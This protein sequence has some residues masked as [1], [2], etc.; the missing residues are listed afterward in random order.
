MFKYAGQISPTKKLNL[1][2]NKIVIALCASIL[3]ASYFPNA[4]AANSV[5]L[6]L[7]HLQK[8]NALSSTQG[9]QQTVNVTSSSNAVLSELKK[10]YALSDNEEFQLLKS[11]HSSS[12]Q[13][14]QRYVQTINGVPVYG[15]QV[16]I[17]V[18]DQ[19][20]Y[21]LGG[22]VLVGANQDVQSGALLRT[23]TD[24][25]AKNLAK[26]YFD[27]N[28][29]KGKL[30]T[31]ERENSLATIALKEQQAFEVKHVTF[32][33]TPYGHVANPIRFNAFVNKQGKVIEAWN[34][35]THAQAS[36]PG[37]NLKTGRYNY[38]TEYN[39][40]EVT[41]NGTECLLENDRVRTLNMNHSKYGGSVHSFTCSTNN[42]KEI[43][44]AYSP[45]NDAHY[46]GGVVFDLYND[47]FQ[48]SPLSQKLEMRV[49]YGN[50]Y[51]N[52]FWD[53]QRMTFGDGASRFYPLVSLDVVAHEVSH[54]FTEQNSGLIYSNQSGGINESFSDVAGEAAEYFMTGSNDWLVGETIF[55]ATGQALRYLE[56][57]TRDGSSIGHADNYYDGLDVHYS[58][59][60]FN[61]AFYLLTN[62]TGWNIQKAFTAYVDANRFY[63]TPSTTYVEG[64]C[65][66]ILAAR[67]KGY[68]WQKAFESFQQV[69][70]VCD[71]IPIDT[72]GDGMPNTWEIT[73][74]L[75]ETSA[76]DAELDGDSD[77]LTNLQEFSYKTN[78]LVP[79]TDG[80]GINDGEEVRIG[81]KPTDVDSDSDGLPDGWEKN[82]GLDPLDSADAIL[83]LD[84]DGFTNSQEYQMGTRANDA[85]SYP[86]LLS[87]LHES[88][89]NGSPIGWSTPTEATKGWIISN[90]NNTHGVAS[91][92]SADIEDNQSSQV[93]FSN[94][95]ASGILTFDY[96]V[97]S[98]KYFDYFEMYLN[99]SLVIKTSGYHS[100]SVTI[101]VQ[102]GFNTLHFKFSKDYSLS[103]GFDSA[104]IDNVKFVAT[105][106]DSDGMSDS[107]ENKYGYD[108][109]NAGDASLDGDNDNL[110]NLEEHNV[111]TNPNLSDS[112]NDG[113][114][115]YIEIN[116]SHSNPTIHDTDNDDIPD[117]WEYENGL[118]PNDPSDRDSDAD[119][120][121][122]SN[123]DEY[124]HQT[125]PQNSDS[126]S[127]LLSDG[128]EINTVGSDPLNS[129]TD[130]DHLPDGWEMEHNLNPLLESDATSDED[131]DGLNALQE[132]EIKSNPNKSD[133]DGDSM[134]DKWEHDNNLDPTDAADAAGDADG[135]SL[136]NLGEYIAK[137]N[138]MDPDTD[139]DGMPD[140]SDSA[141][142]QKQVE[143]GGSSGGSTSMLALFGLFLLALTRRKNR[144]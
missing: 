136:T 72:D 69:G 94:I 100:E 105:D 28:F 19:G 128:E 92:V 109:Q 144:I 76:S 143:T 57:P 36:G 120:D 75:D 54:G 33:A 13:L 132:F 39:H 14:H 139:N 71:D 62:S 64:A 86:P 4:I 20:V 29:A 65:G 70:V 44:G 131:N 8:Q 10:V 9:V 58:S 61:R 15:K 53:G 59:G 107:W 77:A 82:I 52:A 134:P 56:D 142:T 127:D 43:N 67:D 40:L 73:Y 118:N 83:D 88:F 119:S 18:D 17:H 137:T 112:D 37:G 48:L 35:M 34:S 123:Y 68:D 79:D 95:F 21:W 125:N 117:G 47:W 133:S 49:H 7:N 104:W 2:P 31:F 106:S 121:T 140:G 114:S 41:Q 81:T 38:G 97:E 51:E 55:K 12:G 63:W 50:S 110:T 115:D 126:D 116:D 3:P 27:A 25:E 66:V 93:T 138:P 99:D 5:S 74:G 32:I 96:K 42:D 113:L 89:E 45:L 23:L 129:D 108:P 85:Y 103:S 87:T 84:S 6:S 46:F 26:A 80:D 24:L 130:S 60:V 135:D 91:F 11:V 1:R 30:W 98:E 78:P 16:S 102:E 101:A 111:G 122:L 141:P 124:V 22:Q 90:S